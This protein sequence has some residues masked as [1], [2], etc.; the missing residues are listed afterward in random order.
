MLAVGYAYLREGIF[1][2]FC[3]LFNTFLAGL[4][5]FNF[6]EPLADLMDAPLADSFLHGYEDLI[7]LI[8][9]FCVTLG[10]LRTVTNAV[11]PLELKFPSLLRQ[12]G[13]FIFG[14]AN[15]YLVAGFFLCVLQTLPWHENFMFF[16]APGKDV[17]ARAGLSRVLPS[18]LAWLALMHKAGA[19]AFANNEDPDP[20]IAEQGSPYAKYVTFDKYGN[21]ELRYAR[22]RRYNDNREALQY[23]GEFDQQLGRSQ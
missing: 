9:L 21:F 22:Y 4:V 20:N 23:Q 1:T 11:A 19:Y 7:C 15:G 2:G 13:G 3:M 6:W 18:D 10:V 5:A 8:G 16:P 14:V 17:E 12:L